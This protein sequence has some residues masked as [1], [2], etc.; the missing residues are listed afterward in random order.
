MLPTHGFRGRFSFHGCYSWLFKRNVRK[1][2]TGIDAMLIVENSLGQIYLE[3]RNEIRSIQQDLSFEL[4]HY[5]DLEW[6]LDVQVTISIT[7]PQF[8]SSQAEP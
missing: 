7:Q 5:V 4:P 2:K 6:R 3:N 8:V 1:F